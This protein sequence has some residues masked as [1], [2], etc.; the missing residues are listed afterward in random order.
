[1]S[2]DRESVCTWQY[3]N[4]RDCVFLCEF[5]R[6]KWS[7]DP[8]WVPC[9][10]FIWGSRLIFNT[11]WTVPMSA[12]QRGDNI[13]GRPPLWVGNMSCNVAPRFCTSSGVFE[14]HYCSKK[15]KI[16]PHTELERDPRIWEISCTRPFHPTSTPTETTCEWRSWWM[17]NQLISL[18]K[19]FPHK[20]RAWI[21]PG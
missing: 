17:A 20:P 4:Y 9:H 18:W 15:L 5:Q 19:M 1:M 7:G 11:L 21:T 2:Q 3:L 6:E 12:C 16:I 13:G 8:L 10:L 14:M